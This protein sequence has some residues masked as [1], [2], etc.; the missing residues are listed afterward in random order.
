L[1]FQTASI[2]TAIAIATV[3]QFS[4]ADDGHTPAVGRWLTEDHHAV[5]EIGSCD[6]GELCGHLV[7]LQPEPGERGKVPIDDHNPSPELRA[8]PLCGLVMLGGFKRSSDQEWKDGWIYNPENGKT[9]HAQISV[10]DDNT[11]KLRGYVGIPLFGESQVWKRANS[12]IK[13]CNQG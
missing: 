10:V 2:L 12:S 8:R 5:I 7:W 3:K 6:N 1:R 11:L 4:Q 9:Y 13:L